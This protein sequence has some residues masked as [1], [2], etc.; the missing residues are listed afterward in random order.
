VKTPAKAKRV[1]EGGFFGESKI[2]ALFRVNT[3][4][5]TTGGSG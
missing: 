4:F 5:L 3:G 2:K 1:G